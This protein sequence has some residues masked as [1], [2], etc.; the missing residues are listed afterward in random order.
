MR[1]FGFTPVSGIAPCAIRPCVRKMTRIAPFWVMQIWF[2]SGSQM[3]APSTPRAQP[4]RMKS[5][6]PIISPSS[7]HGMHRSTLPANGRPLRW[8]ARTAQMAAA[9]LPLVSHAPR[10]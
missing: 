3:M 4:R 9:R 6:M 5:L 1:V 10:P 7:S 2:S 8:M